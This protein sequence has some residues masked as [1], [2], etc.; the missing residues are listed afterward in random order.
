MICCGTVS[1]CESDRHLRQ[2]GPLTS[3][4]PE[5]FFPLISHD[6]D[7]RIYTQREWDHRLHLEHCS[8]SVPLQRSFESHLTV[9]QM[10]MRCIWNIGMPFKGQYNRQ[11]PYGLTVAL[12]NSSFWSIHGTKSHQT[13]DRN[14]INPSNL[15]RYSTHAAPS[16]KSTMTAPERRQWQ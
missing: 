9:I 14:P 2:H 11:R 6:E 7:G 5:N 10:V 13:A 15:N 12:F 16:S 1:C 8:M 3:P 4:L